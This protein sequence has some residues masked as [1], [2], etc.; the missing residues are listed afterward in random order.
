MTKQET[1]GEKEN[2]MTEA[3]RESVSVFEVVDRMKKQMAFKA[4]TVIFCVGEY[5]YADEYCFFHVFL[6]WI[7]SI[8]PPPIDWYSMHEWNKTEAR[9]LHKPMWIRTV[10]SRS[11]IHTLHTHRSG[12]IN[13]STTSLL[14]GETLCLSNPKNHILCCVSR[15]ISSCLHSILFFVYAHKPIHTS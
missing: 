9:L 1:E 15:K 13:S 11:H 12:M 6:P 2:S 8:V 3:R 7:V 5:E 10:E 4:V 14:A